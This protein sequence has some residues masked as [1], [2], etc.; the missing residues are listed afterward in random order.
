MPTV[1]HFLQLNTILSAT[2]NFIT[3]KLNLKSPEWSEFTGLQ[4]Q[5]EIK[6][7]IQSEQNANLCYVILFH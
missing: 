2:A 4:M 6:P 1:A 7:C 5:L 3:E